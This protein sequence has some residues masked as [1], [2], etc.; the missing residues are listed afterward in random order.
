MNSR[1]LFYFLITYPKILGWR[2][3]KTTSENK[4]EFNQN[5]ATEPKWNLLSVFLF[6]QLSERE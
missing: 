2:R 1:R 5:R 3:K 6:L 4:V